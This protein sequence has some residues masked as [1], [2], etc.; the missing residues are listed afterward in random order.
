MLYTTYLQTLGAL[1]EPSSKSSRRVYPAPDPIHTFTAGFVAGAVQSVFAAPLDAL[2][3]R[4]K[5]NDM[6]EGKYKSIWQ[7]SFEKLREIGI[8]GIS[9]GWTMSFVKDS[10]SCALSFSTFEYTKGQ[11]Y[12]AFL[13]RIYD[14]GHK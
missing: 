9:A 14:P 11:L 1:H 3:I 8:R 12:Y 2:Q 13:P 10:I 4:F 5:T 6:L 7:Y